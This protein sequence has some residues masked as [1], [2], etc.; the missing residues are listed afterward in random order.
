[1]SGPEGHG[2]LACARSPLGAGQSRRS[3]EAKTSCLVAGA[4][5]ETVSAETCRIRPEHKCMSL[6]AGCLPCHDCGDRA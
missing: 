6:G 3:L 2:Q 1:M 5:E 4:G